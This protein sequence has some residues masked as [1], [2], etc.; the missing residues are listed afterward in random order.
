MKSS[1][2]ELIYVLAL[3]LSG[4]KDRAEQFANS[5]FSSE[6]ER[7]KTKSM[8][9]ALS[10]DADAAKNWQEQYLETYG[11]DDLYSLVFNAQQGTQNEA[12]RLAGLVDRRSFGYM[13]LLNAIYICFCGA[14][15]D[16]DATP[17]FASMLAESG[18]PWPPLE[19]I[20]FPLKDW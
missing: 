3:S 18:L 11:P 13:T 9:A 17:V 15:F 19:P 16:L 10:G 1:G 6:Q 2:L 4:E 7:L 5:G 20:D 12:N 14:P 8:L